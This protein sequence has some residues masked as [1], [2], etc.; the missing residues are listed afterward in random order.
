MNSDTQFEKALKAAAE[1]S[2]KNEI[3]YLNQGE[4]EDRREE[5]TLTESRIQD[6]S[7]RISSLPVEAKELFFG[8]YCFKMQAEEAGD[9]Y[10]IDSPWGRFR[11][12]KNL[13]STG[14]EPGDG[15]RISE[16]SFQK[17]SEIALKEY[18]Y[19]AEQ[20]AFALQTEQKSK[21]VRHVWKYP[22]KWAAA[23][24]VFLSVGLGVT[25]TSNAE[26]RRMIVE[27]YMRVFP[28]HSEIQTEGEPEITLET[29]KEYHP[30]FIPERYQLDGKIE[31]SFE[32]CYVYQDKDR[33]QMSITL[34]LPGHE[35]S[36]DTEGLVIEE[37]IWNG[38][39]A[40]IMTDNDNY[41]T[42]ACSKDGIPV[43]IGGY[44]SKEEMIEIANGIKK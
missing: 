29:L 44:L 35:I 10:G 28:T 39:K 22:A 42:F 8:I 4:E 34:Q 9:V 27:W 16:D 24:V 2:F 15:R 23:A 33:N 3:M 41:G 13:L 5:V 18:V 40:I 43:F 38:E 20:E 19:Q 17:A 7:L 37:T 31:M 11:Y 6:L 32:I 14:M 1:A 36:I 26:I 25:I 12:Y 30:G 21:R